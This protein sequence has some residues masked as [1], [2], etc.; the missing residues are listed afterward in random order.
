MP[1]EAPLR[2]RERR[3]GAPAPRQQKQ[4]FGLRQPAEGLQA[5][6]GGQRHA[7]LNEGEGG[8]ALSVL[9]REARDVLDRAR[10]GDDVELAAPLER[11]GGKPL[12]D[13]VILSASRRRY[14]MDAL[15]K[16]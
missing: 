7:I 5:G 13:G 12:P 1:T 6:V 11:A 16:A 15:R 4:R 9:A 10:R 3:D 2:S 14:R 8:N